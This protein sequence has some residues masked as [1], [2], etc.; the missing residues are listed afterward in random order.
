MKVN[1]G[2]RMSTRLFF[3]L[4]A[5]GIVARVAL[6]LSSIGTNDVIFKMMWAGMIEKYGVI[7]AYAK[8]DVI[9]T[10]GAPVALFPPLTLASFK[11]MLAISKATSI[12][13]TDVLRGVQVVADLVAVSALLGIARVRATWNGY[14]LALFY[15]LTPTV[16]FVSA[17]H[18]NTDSTMVALLL[19]ATWLA[20]QNRALASGVALAAAIGIKILPLFIVPF[21]LVAMQKNARRFLTGFTAASALIFVPAAVVGGA[22]V[23]NRLLAYSGYAGKW[24]IPAVLLEAE[25]LIAAPRTTVMFDIALWYARHGKYLVLGVLA[26]ILL[27]FWKRVRTSE[28]RVEVLV[29]TIPVVYL[30]VL[31]LGPGFGVQY[32]LWPIPLL[33][34]TFGRRLAYTIAATF[35][36]YSF[37]AYT[38]WSGGF[39]WWYADSMAPHPLKHW[40]VWLGIPV[41]LLTGIAAAYGLRSVAANGQRRGEVSA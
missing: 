33:L 19:L 40:I 2:I 9:A 12:A 27:I 15:F 36:A 23:L 31:F 6:I 32:L 17:F 18:C 8:H 39:P 28:E 41:W 14:E 5:A 38:I 1:D 11:L 21:F 26:L 13:Y 37:A 35:S 3:L 30:T 20:V 4:L 25:K 7:G 22:P 24:G 10:S 16:I 29:Q 34:A